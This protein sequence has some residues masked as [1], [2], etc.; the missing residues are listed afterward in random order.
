[1]SYGW[2]AMTLTED[3]LERD[4]PL[5]VTLPILTMCNFTKFGIGGAKETTHGIC[6]LPNNIVHQKFYLFLWFWLI[7]LLTATIILLLYRLALYLLPSF[8]AY[9]TNKVWAGGDICSVNDTLFLQLIALVID[10]T[11]QSS[12]K[13]LTR[14]VDNKTCYSDWII[15]TFFHSNLTTV[16]FQN[17]IDDL[18]FYWKSD[19]YKGRS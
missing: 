18:A 4:D 12:E 5:T 13:R 16:N 19:E 10:E 7:F 2:D 3:P 9:V 14:F 1:M 11:E 8:R 17:F 6:V 15:L